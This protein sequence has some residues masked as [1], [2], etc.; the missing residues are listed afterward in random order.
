MKIETIAGRTPHS[1]RRLGYAALVAVVAIC[2]WPAIE[3]VKGFVV[4]AAVH[5]AATVL[6]FFAGF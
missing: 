5:Y 4:I 1:H 2:A 3:P 6:N